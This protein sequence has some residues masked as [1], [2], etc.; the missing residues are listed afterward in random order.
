ME[1]TCVCGLSKVN[2]RKPLRNSTNRIV[3]MFLFLSL[4]SCANVML[5]IIE[6]KNNEWTNRVSFVGFFMFYSV[7]R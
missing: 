5:F 3:K 4:M 2:F 6:R 1:H 7:F